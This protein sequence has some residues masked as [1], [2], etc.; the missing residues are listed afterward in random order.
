MVV[1]YTASVAGVLT[2]PSQR[3]EPSRWRR[4]RWTAHGCCAGQGHV[5]AGRQLRLLQPRCSP[6]ITRQATSAMEIMRSNSGKP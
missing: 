5:E 1:G 3:F 2:L 6:L 4:A